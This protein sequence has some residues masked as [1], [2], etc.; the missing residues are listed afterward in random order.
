MHDMGSYLVQFSLMFLFDKA[1]HVYIQASAVLSDDEQVDLETAF[2]LSHRDKT[3]Q[4]ATS[5]RRPSDYD[6]AVFGTHGMLVS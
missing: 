6:I 2:V 3:A 4:F 5:L 1:K